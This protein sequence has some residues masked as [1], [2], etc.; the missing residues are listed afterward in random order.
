MPSIESCFGCQSSAYDSSNFVVMRSKGG[1]R[2][3]VAESCQPLAFRE[4]VAVSEPTRTPR[5]STTNVDEPVP[6]AAICAGRPA[7]KVVS[8]RIA[9]LRWPAR[10][11]M[12]GDADR[13]SIEQEYR[14]IAHGSG[15][16]DR[17]D[18]G[19]LRIEGADAVSF[20]HALVTNDIEAVRAGGGAYAAWLTPQGRMIADMRV[21]RMADAL[22]LDVPAS[23]AA[24]LASRLD[25]L[26]FSEDAR[27]SDVSRALSQI[28][29]IGERAASSTAEALGLDS[30]QVQ[31][32]PLWS[33][34]PVPDGFVA[35]T[36][37]ARV[38]AFAVFVNS[39]AREAAM[40]KL[41][42]A[43]SRRISGAL[44]DA[45][46]VDAG[47][48][49]FGTDMDTTTIP[50]EAGLL[51]RA[52][53]TTKGCYVGQEIVVRILHRGGGRVAKTLVRH[54]LDGDVLPAPGSTIDID[55]RAARVTSA[56]WSPLEQKAVVLAYLPK[57]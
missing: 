11:F 52:I 35:R 39:I 37:D 10:R 45:L 51:E 29:V 26:I 20:L 34:L 19:C 24:E 27:V 9:T 4:I 6:S 44:V 54:V 33:H 14:T 32:L 21:Y 7:A 53:S 18:R 28:A 5:N 50:L 49:R 22:L 42:L 3:P 46:R 2:R 16:A 41:E 1:A 13:R 15:W 12:A 43:G 31:A 23:D 17:A 25:A 8:A 56:A 55:G 57:S 47:H 48:P 30:T 40:R 36:D 38:P